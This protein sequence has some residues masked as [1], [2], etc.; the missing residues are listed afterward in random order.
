VYLKALT[1]SYT[2]GLEV[3]ERKRPLGNPGC[4]YITNVTINI[5][6]V[7]CSGVDWIYLVQDRN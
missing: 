6:K 5:G 2:L 4:R 7:W 3:A 1:V